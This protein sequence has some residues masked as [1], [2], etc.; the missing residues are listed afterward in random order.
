[1][2]YQKNVVYDGGV[3]LAKKYFN[4]EGK[5]S[6]NPKGWWMSEKFDG[7]RALWNGSELQSRTGKPINA[8]QSFLNLLPSGIA[9]DGELFVGRGKFSETSSITSKKVP[10]EAEWKKIKYQVFDMPS[11]KTPFEERMKTLDA[12]LDTIGSDRLLK[13]NHIQVESEAHLL[14][15]HKKI[16]DNGGEGS[17]IRKQRSLYEGKRSSTLL[18]VKDFKDEDAVIIAHLEG[19]GRLS[20]AL[21][22]VSVKWVKRPDVTFQVGSGFSDK[23]RFG[24]YKKEFPI[25]TVIIVKY[26]ELDEKS[27]KPRFPTFLG[28]RHE[29]D[30]INEQN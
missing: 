30:I 16:V 17:M 19:K 8:P 29:Q 6:V 18:K 24:D 27:G 20:N 28:K 22:K 9:L 23:E 10:M 7:V 1:M 26:F 15:L 2:S 14:K 21:G 25:G 13:T 4:Y 12:L 3:L 11:D 5:P